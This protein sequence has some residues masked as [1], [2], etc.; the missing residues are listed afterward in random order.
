MPQVAISSDFLTAILNLPKTQQKKVN[1]FVNKFRNDPYSSGINYEKINDAANPYM[2]SVRI[3]KAYRGIILKPEHGDVFI[4]LWVDHHDEAYEWARNH[5]CKINPTTG[6]I[7]LYA[8]ESLV[9]PAQLKQ[10]PEPEPET[11]KPVVEIESTPLFNDLMDE[12]LINIGLPSESVEQVRKITNLF[13]LEGIKEL[14]PNDAYEAL[15]F[16]ADGIPYEEVLEDFTTDE[17]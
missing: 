13:E 16:V 1:Q 5:Q 17:T 3:D 9:V 2:R 6:A 14:L 7:Q 10:E 4:L 11:V 15:Y 8:T 12:Q